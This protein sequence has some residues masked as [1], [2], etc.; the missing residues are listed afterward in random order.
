[1]NKFAEKHGRLADFGVKVLAVLIVLVV[2]TIGYV[3]WETYPIPTGIVIGL[4]FFHNMYKKHK[5]MN[6]KE[7]NNEGT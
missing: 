5:K 7:E 2:F 6:N 1:M 4:V 3:A